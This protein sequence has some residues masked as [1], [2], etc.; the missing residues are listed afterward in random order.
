MRCD[1]STS[2][3]Y[4]YLFCT[5]HSY[6]PLNSLSH[7]ILTTTLWWRYWALLPI[8]LMRKHRQ[9]EVKMIY[10]RSLTSWV[11]ELRKILW[12]VNPFISQPCVLWP[13]N[14]QHFGWLPVE[15]PRSILHYTT[16]AF[17]RWCLQKTHH[18]IFQEPFHHLVSPE[19]VGDK[20]H[21][22]TNAWLEKTWA[23]VADSNS[24]PTIPVTYYS[25]ATHPPL[26]FWSQFCLLSVLMFVNPD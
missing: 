10:P 9:G 5:R 19:Y 3:Y 14:R 21:D 25:F 6:K 2:Y 4:W 15:C 13:G 20:A 16:S 23:T 18:W 12:I 22:M 26:P 11:T 24:S 8:L 7:L 1:N 17:Q